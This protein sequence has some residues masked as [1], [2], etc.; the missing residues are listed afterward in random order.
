M[1]SDQ[2]ELQMLVVSLKEATKEVIQTVEQLLCDDTTQQ[3]EGR[4]Q[5][6]NTPADF[7]GSSG[8]PLM[9]SLSY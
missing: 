3:E 5:V 4:N 7:I 2:C 6:Q 1:D 8:L 9:S